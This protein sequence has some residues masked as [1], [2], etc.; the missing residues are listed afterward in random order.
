MFDSVVNYFSSFDPLHFVK[1]GFL[2]ILFLFIIFLLIVAK[3]VSA[4]NK[5]LTAR[6]AS[7]ALLLFSLLLVLAAVSLFAASVAIL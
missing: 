3:Q 6:Y 2:I 1:L 5:I 7:T 4:M